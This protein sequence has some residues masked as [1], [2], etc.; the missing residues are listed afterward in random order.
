MTTPFYT[1]LIPLGQ[2]SNVTVASLEAK[3]RE[4]LPEYEI[5]S[6]GNRIDVK[7]GGWSLSIHYTSEDWVNIEA[8]EMAEMHPEWPNIDSLRESDTRL[9]MESY[10][11]DLNMDHFNTYLFTLE[12]IDS[13]NGVLFKYDNRDGNLL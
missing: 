9:K 8:Q 2:D 1:A 6:D 11:D 5:A 10:S 3:L 7:R 12:V 4:R 13:F